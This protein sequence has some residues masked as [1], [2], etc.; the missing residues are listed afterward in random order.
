M[1]RSHAPPVVPAV[2][3]DHRHPGP[4]APELAG[5]HPTVGPVVPLARHHQHPLPVGPAHHLEPGH[6]HRLAGPLDEHLHRGGGLG[7]PIDGLHLGD[8]EDRSHGRG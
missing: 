5:R 1:T 8:G 2:G 4:P 7:P 3:V 6:R